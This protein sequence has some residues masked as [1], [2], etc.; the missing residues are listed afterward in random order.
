LDYVGANSFV[1]LLSRVAILVLLFLAGLETS[2]LEMK[3]GGK[4]AFYVASI[5]IVSPMVLGLITAA[6]SA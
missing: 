5:G 2:I 1:D 3:R 6:R 4:T